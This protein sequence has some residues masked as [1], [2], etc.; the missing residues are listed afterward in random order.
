MREIY[1]TARFL[2]KDG[3]KQLLIKELKLLIPETISEN[4]CLHYELTEEIVYTGSF[5]D[6]WDVCLIERWRSREDFDAHC[7]MS[8]I[9]HFFDAIAKTCVEKSDVRLYSPLSV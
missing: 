3:C 6:S 8:Y 2:A 9:K 7:N 4:G 1:C 5:G